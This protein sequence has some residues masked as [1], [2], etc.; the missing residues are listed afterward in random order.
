MNLFVFERGV[1]VTACFSDKKEKLA[2]LETM[3]L[4]QHGLNF[5]ST[6]SNPKSTY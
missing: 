5:F 6:F 4:T 3:A 1:L 2:G